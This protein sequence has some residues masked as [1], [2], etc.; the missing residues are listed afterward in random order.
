MEPV[1]WFENPFDS[2]YRFDMLIEEKNRFVNCSLLKKIRDGGSVA[3]ENSYPNPIMSAP[4]PRHDPAAAAESSGE[5]KQGGGALKR[6]KPRRG[7]TDRRPATEEELRGLGRAISPEEVL[8]LRAVTR[9]EEENKTG[10][11]LA[12]LTARSQRAARSE[13]SSGCPCLSFNPDYFTIF[14]LLGMLLAF[15]D[16]QHSYTLK[17]F[18]LHCYFFVCFYI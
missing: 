11:V 12:S 17:Y 13:A 10:G 1:N 6:L 4:R 9:G 14:I 3:E 7:Q 2:V 8:G 5:R 16:F 18:V 15:T